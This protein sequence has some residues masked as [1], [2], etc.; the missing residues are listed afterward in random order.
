MQKLPLP[1]AGFMRAVPAFVTG[2]IVGLVVVS[3]VRVLQGLVGISDLP[4][5]LVFNM[6]DSAEKAWWD[7]EA[8]LMFGLLFGAISSILGAGGLRGTPFDMTPHDSALMLSEPQ[9]KL[10]IPLD[11]DQPQAVNEPTN[12][13]LSVLPATG[14]LVAVMVV[15]LVLIYVFP[16]LGFSTEQVRGEAA[17]VVTFK[18]EDN[19][20]LLGLYTFENVNQ[21]ALFLA[22]SVIVMLLV[23]GAPISL[24]L[25]FYLLNREV[26][27]AKQAAAVPANTDEW[28]P[29]R[30][31]GFFNE[32]MLDIVKM[33]SDIVRPR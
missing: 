7:D 23:L 4:N 19:F 27:T 1:P 32:W 5:L 33:S 2:F 16:Q 20:N 21:S 14:I 29:I 30:L 24:A 25:A 9:Q 31:A 28:F 13:L 11:P 22:F 3:L 8:L 18:G 10:R 17:S 6:F 15:T 12:Q 26:E